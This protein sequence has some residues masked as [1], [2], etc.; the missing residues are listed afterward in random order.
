MAAPQEF[1]GDAGSGSA[2]DA[3]DGDLAHGVGLVV[4]EMAEFVAVLPLIVC[5]YIRSK[6]ILG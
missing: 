4:S 3:E 2:G 6:N 5:F 1:I